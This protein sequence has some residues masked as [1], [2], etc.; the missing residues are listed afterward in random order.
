MR[1][2]GKIAPYH[3][4]GAKATTSGTWSTYWTWPDETGSSTAFAYQA[5]KMRKNHFDVAKSNAYAKWLVNSPVKW[6]HCDPFIAR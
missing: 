3:V 6:E 4:R 5:R 1:C 2:G